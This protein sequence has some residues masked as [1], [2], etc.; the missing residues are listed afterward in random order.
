MAETP[1]T[2]PI[3][4]IPRPAPKPLGMSFGVLMQFVI[5]PM[6][7]VAI[8][9]GFFVLG[10]VLFGGGDHAEDYLNRIRSRSGREAWQAAYEL[11]VLLARDEKVRKDPALADQV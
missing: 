7:I 8:L 4:R 6:T 11:S 5:L 10:G 2:P 1:G 3:T 9:V